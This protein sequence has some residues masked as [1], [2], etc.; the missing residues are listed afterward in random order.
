MIIFQVEKC[1]ISTSPTHRKEHLA[2]PFG[3]VLQIPD[4][5]KYDFWSELW[6]TFWG[7][8]IKHIFLLESI[9]K[10]LF[11]QFEIEIVF[12][13]LINEYGLKLN[14]RF[15]GGLKFWFIHISSGTLHPCRGTQL[16]LRPWLQFFLFRKT[17]M[18]HEP[19]P[20]PWQQILPK[21]MYFNIT[22]WSWKTDVFWYI[23]FN[24]LA[25]W[26]FQTVWKSQGRWLQIS[27]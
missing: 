8:N 4:R 9:P 13:I 11:V 1:S 17:E 10:I 18:L 16:L 6:L 15:S 5:A 3:C 27:C 22:M 7:W 12:P 24:H 21:I 25:H 23:F 20:L 26:K 2:Y 19:K 14:W